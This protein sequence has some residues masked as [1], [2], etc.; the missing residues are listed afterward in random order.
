MSQNKGYP[1]N[2]EVIVYPSR[3]GWARMTYIITKTERDVQTPEKAIERLK[4]K[5]DDKGGYRDTLFNIITK[6]PFLFQHPEKNLKSVYMTFTEDVTEVV[7]NI[8]KKTKK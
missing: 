3:T 1:M 4:Q 7:L 5:I 2:A 6:F 8:R